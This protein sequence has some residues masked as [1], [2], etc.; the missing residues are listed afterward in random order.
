MIRMLIV[1]LAVLALTGCQAKP[2]N[3]ATATPPDA[4]TAAAPNLINQLTDQKLVY[5]CPQC[6]MDFDG[7]GKCTMDGAD[8]V[9]TKVEYVCPADGKPVE[10]AGKCPRCNMDA[11]IVKTAMAAPAAGGK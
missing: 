8:L 10:R 11:K 4:V 6:G 2:K 9:P 5:E 1:A 7:P 3:P